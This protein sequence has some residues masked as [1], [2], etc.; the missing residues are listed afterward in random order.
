VQT[1]RLHSLAAAFA[2]LAALAPARA[3]DGASG[4][5]T[6]RGFEGVLRPSVLRADQ[7]APAWSLSERMRHYG[8]PGV[9]VAVLHDGEVVHAAGYGLREAGTAEKVDAD[10]LFSVGSVSKVVAAGATLR[11][12]SQGRLDLDRDVGAYLRSWRIP[13]FGG[14]AAP[15]VTLRM[16]LSHTAGFNVHGFEDFQ[17][18]AAVPDVLQ[19]LDG[20]APAKH[21]PVRLVHP[22]G[23]RLD[24]SGGGVT[25]EQLVLTDATGRPFEALAR[26]TVFDPLRM[27]R[28]TFESPLAA[29]RGNIAKAHGSD[30]RP[31]AR[32]R[33]WE[34]FPELAASGLWTSANDL[35]LYVRALIRSYRGSDDF[36]P[37]ALAREMMTEVSPSEH[38][39][40]P[41]LAGTAEKRV[42]HHGGSNDSYRAFI[43][44][45]LYSGDGV[46]ILTNGARGD[47]LAG[48]IRNAIADA[49]GWPTQ[50]PLRTIAI[51]ADDPQAARDAGTYVFDDGIPQ[52]WQKRLNEAPR[53]LR[54]EVARGRLTGYWIG[55]SKPVE[56]LPLAPNRYTSPDWESLQIEF[57]RD[58]HGA[59]SALS[60]DNGVS[61]AYYRRKAAP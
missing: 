43:E 50:R 57:H 31:R 36:L 21:E 9:A 15:T 44:G 7:P 41:R 10:T 18:G 11:L 28:S 4:A 37:R 29:T 51:V 48:E 35:A 14:D 6:S 39:L 5:Q 49:W 60:L 40:G 38:G 13:P 34:T 2:L 12:V 23:E 56:L 17:P 33:G 25:V 26:E 55:S 59:T 61:R 58:A 8:V 45:N 30:G 19:T 24:Y 16:L 20:K 27:N 22:P 54:V 53:E 1:I 52:A 47:E 46:V 3:A 42:F 32:P